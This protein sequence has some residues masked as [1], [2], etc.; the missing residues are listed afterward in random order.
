MSATTWDYSALGAEGELISGELT[1]ISESDAVARVRRLGYRPTRVRECRSTL[2]SRDFE[3]S[4]LAPKVKPAELAGG[5]RQLAAMLGAGVPMMRALSVLVD[6]S[7]APALGKA[8]RTVRTDVEAGE[9]FSVALSRH[10]RVF[11]TVFVALV[12]AGEASGALDE[13]LAQAADALE[14]RAALRR[15]VRSALAYPIAVLALVGVVVLAM[16]VFVVPVF[17][18]IYEDLGGSLPLATRIVL[19]LTG[20]IGS[21]VLVLGCVT[22]AA[23]AGFRRWRATP[24]GGLAVDKATLHLPVVGGLL[25]RSV[26]ARTARTLAVLVRAGV[27]LLE[28]LE[29]AAH[30]SSNQVMRRAVLDASKA[31]RGGRTLSSEFAASSEIPSL[32]S[33]VIAVGEE[34]GELDEMLGVVADIYEDEVDAAAATFSSVVEPLLIAFLGLVVGGLVLAL[35]LP[36]F[37]LVDLVQ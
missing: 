29:I 27:P 15:R 36:M 2:L 10:P 21:N 5:V 23:V 3:I 13:V 22:V 24:V 9:S 35:Y 18:G 32:F 26:L 19:G 1:A 7:E 4:F 34:S 20:F 17:R 12:R 28:A 31:V 6:Q 11:D 14:R 37:R 30:T 8:W 25:R 16:S 33:Q